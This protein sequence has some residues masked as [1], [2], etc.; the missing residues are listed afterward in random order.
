M[1]DSAA[2]VEGDGSAPG[3]VDLTGGCLRTS[4]GKLVLDA[5][6][7]GVLPSRTPSADEHLTLGFELHSPSGESYV[8]AEGSSR[9]WA[10]YLTRGQGRRE[11]PGALTIDGS[12][13]RIKTPLSA[14]DGATA[15][16]WK[17]ESSWSKS[18][19]LKTSYAFDA[20][21]ARGEAV[22]RPDR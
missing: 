18:T 15:L 12:R 11:L 7:N 14:G 13:L 20:A 3:Y 6:V 9:G 10:A 5:T 22:F 21:P 4:G 2:D 16:R 1:T 8:F 19:L 17:V